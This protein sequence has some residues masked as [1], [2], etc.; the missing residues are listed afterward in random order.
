[1]FYQYF[2]VFSNIFFCFSNLYFRI[3]YI[4][5]PFLDRQQNRRTCSTI[6]YNINCDFKRRLIQNYYTFV[7]MTLQFVIRGSLGSLI[8]YCQSDSNYYKPTYFR[9]RL[10]FTKFA[11]Q[12]RRISISSKSII[13]IIDSNF[14]D[15]LSAQVNLRKRVL[16][17]KS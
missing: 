16:Q 2:N 12:T 13:L 4:D 8:V 1:M 15:N 11:I 14:Y 10:T 5:L 3:F 9:S 17:L 6:N 7:R